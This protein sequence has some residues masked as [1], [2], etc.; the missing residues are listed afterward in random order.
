M[1]R[2]KLINQRVRGTG[3]EGNQEKIDKRDKY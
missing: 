1:K 3:N 2:E